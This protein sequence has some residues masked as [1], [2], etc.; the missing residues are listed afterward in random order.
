[1][2][3][4]IHRLNKISGS[5]ILAFVDILVDNDLVIKGFKIVSGNKGLF[6]P[7]PSE[8]SRNGE[9]Y[10]DTIFFLNAMTKQALED[11]ILKEWKIMQDREEIKNLDEH[12]SQ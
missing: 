10:F 12:T 9:K 7:N 8:Q 6:V 11:M 4:K 3:F 2:E 1:M 5:K